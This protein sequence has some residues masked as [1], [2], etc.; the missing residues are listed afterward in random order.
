MQEMEQNGNP[1]W[2]S[3]PL[4]WLLSGAGDVLMEP[5]HAQ[6]CRNRTRGTPPPWMGPGTR[7]SAREKHPRAGLSH[8]LVQRLCCGGSSASPGTPPR[9]F[10]SQRLCSAVRDQK[11][12]NPLIAQFVSKGSLITS[13][14]AAPIKQNPK[15]F[16]QS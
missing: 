12:S 11:A 15:G 6:S 8:P 16:R 14:L 13:P 7:V 1:L 4:G 10:S 9:G 2:S 3:S 5:S